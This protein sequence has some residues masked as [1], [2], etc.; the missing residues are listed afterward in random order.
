VH[1]HISHGWRFHRR[2]GRRGWKAWR[3]S[4]PTGVD[5]SILFFVPFPAT[6]KTLRG[7]ATLLPF[8]LFFFYPDWIPTRRRP[9]PVLA[10]SVS[11]LHRQPTSACCLFDRAFPSTK[12]RRSPLLDRISLNTKGPRIAL[13]R[14]GREI[15]PVSHISSIHPSISRD[16]VGGRCEM[17]VLSAALGAKV[18]LLLSYYPCHQAKQKLYRA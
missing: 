3:C 17:T 5:D 9:R 8:F 7:N 12:G 18:G 14:R 11:H 4:L 10:P 16:L 1:E 13:M 2:L 15:T 6:F